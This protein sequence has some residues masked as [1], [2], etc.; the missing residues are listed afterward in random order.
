MP[1]YPLTQP[2]RDDVYAYKRSG[3]TA[4]LGT[5]ALYELLLL[6]AMPRQFVAFRQK[7]VQA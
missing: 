5:A 4:A 2:D 1:P 6:Q 7:V 3:R